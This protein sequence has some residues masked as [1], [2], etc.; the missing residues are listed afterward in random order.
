MTL[1]E[2]AQSRLADDLVPGERVRYALIAFRPGG[3]RNTMIAGAAGIAGVAGAA[4]MALA[5]RRG[6]AEAPEAPIAIPGRIILTLTTHRLATFTVG[7]IIR[8]AP[9]KL[10]HSWTLDQLAW[11]ADP[12]LVPGVAQALRCSIGVTGTGVLGFEFPR[13]QVQEG[14]TM[15]ARLARE[16][17]ELG[18]DPAS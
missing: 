17:R 9:G 7:G 3:V 10:L 11:V 18:E 2:K 15:I 12:V 16:L 13:L 8:A 14:R 1:Q 6:K 4:G 5:A